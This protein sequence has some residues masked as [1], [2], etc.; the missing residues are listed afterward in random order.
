MILMWVR[1]QLAL[2]WTQDLGVEGRE[3]ENFIYFMVLYSSQ[4]CVLA[5]PKH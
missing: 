2:A 4:K 1:G 3:R 5:F